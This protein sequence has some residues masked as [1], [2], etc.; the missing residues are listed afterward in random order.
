MSV[1][2][3]IEQ[4][5]TAAFAPVSLKIVDESH[6]HAGHVGARPEGGTHF[7]VEIVS[8]AFD[9]VSRVARQRMVYELLAE[10][11]EG[12][13]HALSLSASPPPAA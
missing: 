6:L 12:P 3:I 9:G 8:A 11:L 2:R 1:T 10:E 7:R 4:K 5:L 13:V